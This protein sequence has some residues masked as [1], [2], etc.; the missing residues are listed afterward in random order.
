[1][2]YDVW[3]M[4]Y[5]VWCMVYDVWCMMRDVNVWEFIEIERLSEWDYIYFFVTYVN[6]II[7][8]CI[9]IVIFNS[10]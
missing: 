5:D 4:M 6:S 7:D 10:S 3:C 9:V 2:M 1:M 8:T